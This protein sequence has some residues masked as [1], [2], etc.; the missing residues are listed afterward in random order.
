MCVTNNKY[1]LP[2]AVSVLEQCIHAMCLRASLRFFDKNKKNKEQGCR[3][4]MKF[5]FW[6]ITY[7]W[8]MG[9]DISTTG[10]IKTVRSNQNSESNDDM[11][12]KMTRVTWLRRSLLW[13][14]ADEV[15]QGETLVC[16]H[17]CLCMNLWLQTCMHVFINTDSFSHYTYILTC[18]GKW[19][20][21]HMHTYMHARTHTHTHTHTY[22]H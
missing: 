2:V 1:G 6:I 19:K 11:M 9:C 15:V 13:Q 16:A 22:I 20:H 21:K 5:V 18:T 8:Q 10:T 17:T 3:G 12:I 7:V 14:L 4:S